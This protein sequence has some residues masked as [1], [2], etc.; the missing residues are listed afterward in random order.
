MI[1]SEKI[2]LSAQTILF[3]ILSL[4]PQSFAQEIDIYIVNIV[5][6]LLDSQCCGQTGGLAGDQRRGH[7]TQ[8][9]QS[10]LVGRDAASRCQ[11]VLYAFGGKYPVG[12]TVR[13]ASSVMLGFVAFD[14]YIHEVAISANLVVEALAVQPILNR[15]HIVALDAPA[16]AYSQ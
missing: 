14:V 3:E 7:D 2:G 4:F 12:D 16:F 5:F 13:L 15:E 11:Q 10:L 6:G 8:T 1:F 9:A